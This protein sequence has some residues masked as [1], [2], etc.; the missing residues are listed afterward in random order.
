[1]TA[2]AFPLAW[3]HGW[4]RNRHAKRSRFRCTFA[5]VRDELVAEIKRLGGSYIVLSTNI[6]LKRDGMPYANRAEPSDSGV[7]VY[8][9]RRGKQMVFACDKWDRVQDNMRAIQHTIKALR[10][11]E[12]WGASDMMERAYAAFESLPP[13]TRATADCWQI[14]GVCAGASPDEITRAYHQKAMRAHPDTGGSEGAM[15][16]LNQ[17]RD[18]A[19]RYSG[20]NRA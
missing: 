3:P 11:A 13:P 8:F 5:K 10:G 16:Q 6:P 19:I 18:D 17:A 4:K 14:L 12:R 2:E 1:M 20:M 9:F 15:I 7:A